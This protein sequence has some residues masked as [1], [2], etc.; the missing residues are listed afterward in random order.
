MS[1]GITGVFYGVF[2]YEELPG[3]FIYG[4]LPGF[5][6]YEEL[7][8]FFIYAERIFVYRFLICKEEISTIF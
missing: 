6:I 5:F 1:R 3:F 4:E 2:I 7:P 8:G